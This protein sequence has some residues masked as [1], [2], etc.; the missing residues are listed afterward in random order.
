VL[1]CF[2]DVGGL[3]SSVLLGLLGICCRLVGCIV[4][5]LGFFGRG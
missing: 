3:A 1:G 5:G 4:V 2:V